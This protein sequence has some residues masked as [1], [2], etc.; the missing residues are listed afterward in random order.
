VSFAD[1]FT[2]MN[3]GEKGSVVAKRY[4][5]W[6][7]A[8]D[9][10]LEEMI[11]K[12]SVRVL[13]AEAISKKFKVRVTKNAVIG[14]SHRIGAVALQARDFSAPLRP[15]KTVRVLPP[16]RPPQPPK[17]PPY[18]PRPASDTCQYLFGEPALRNFCDKPAVRTLRSSSG[19]WCAQHERAVYMIPGVSKA[20]S[21][22]PVKSLKVERAVKC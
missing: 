7:K 16:P 1:I 2:M 19:R 5:G 3:S 20:L 6:T 9:K 11:S 21:I 13:I 10:M 14:R 8:M 22:V 12:G 4:I 15:P 18:V 17:E